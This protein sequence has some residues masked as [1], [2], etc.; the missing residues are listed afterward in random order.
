MKQI[1]LMFA[2]LIF[3]VNVKAQEVI[4]DSTSTNQN[5]VI[6]LDGNEQVENEEP[7]CVYSNGIAM[8]FPKAGLTGLYNPALGWSIAQCNFSDG[9]SIKKESLILITTNPN[10]YS[11]FDS[12]SR[13]L[14]RFT[15]QSVS[16]L[17][18]DLKSKVE[19]KYDNM[20]MSN[21]LYKFYKSYVRFQLDSETR[22]KLLNPSIGIVK[23]RIVFTNGNVKDYELTGKRVMKFPEELRESYMQASNANKQRLNNSD[24][25]TF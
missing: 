3:S 24:D 20:Y 18:R 25:S 4:I 15:D 19:R 11:S 9:S 6:I 17:H 16:T 1:Y 10:D 13:I 23:I 2:L 5:D 12:D 22:E 21:T 7:T 8:N 14:I